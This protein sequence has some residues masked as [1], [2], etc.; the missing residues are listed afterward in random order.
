MGGNSV[1]RKIL[2][3]KLS[4]SLEGVEVHRFS[5]QKRIGIESLLKNCLTDDDAEV[6]SMANCMSKTLRIVHGGAGAER[7]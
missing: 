3:T 2:L 5:L 4:Q 1:D 6:V 7:H